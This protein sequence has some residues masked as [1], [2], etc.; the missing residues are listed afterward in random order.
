MYSPDGP[1]RIFSDLLS[2]KLVASGT[3]TRLILYGPFRP[4]MTEYFSPSDE[5]VSLICVP[6]HL[7]SAVDSR[8]HG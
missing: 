8:S 7:F 5:K 6:T 2:H 3:S 4:S 1:R